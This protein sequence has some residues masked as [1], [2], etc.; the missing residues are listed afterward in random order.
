MTLLNP[1]KTSFDQVD[2]PSAELL[3]KTIDFFEKKGKN[4]LKNDDHER[5]W[6]DD[7]LAFQKQEKLFANFLTP[8][9]YGNG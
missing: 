9:Q 5:R 8:A 1:K 6:Y 3:K 4:S 2:A 7:F